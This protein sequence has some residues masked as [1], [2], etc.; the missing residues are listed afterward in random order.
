MIDSKELR[1]LAIYILGIL[2]FTYT[3][4]FIGHVKPIPSKEFNEHLVFYDDMNSYLSY[5]KQ[6]ANG[7]WLFQN[8]F[9]PEEHSGVFINL[10][11]LVLGKISRIFKT[12]LRTDFQIERIVGA[13]TLIFGF[14]LLSS[15]FIQNKFVRKVALLVFSLGGGFGW[16]YILS[17]A[18]QKLFH[19]DILTIPFVPR[20]TSSGL[21]PFFQ[22]MLN[23]HF[24]IAHGILLLTYSLYTI[25]EM[26]NDVKYYVFSGISCA[27]LGFVRPFDMLVC[28]LA[29]FMFVILLYISKRELS[30]HQ[31]F[32]RFLPILMGLPVMLYNLYVFKLHPVFK[33]WN[34]QNVFTERPL[35]ILLFSMGFVPFLVLNNIGGFANLREKETKN[36]FLI[37]TIA[38]ISVLAF[39]T[40]F[41]KFAPQFGT[42]WMGSLVI[43]GIMKVEKPLLS[44]LSRKRYIYFLLFAFLLVNSFTSIW[45]LKWKCDEVWQGKHHTDSRLITAF[46]WLE[47]NSSPSDIVLSSY[48]TG[49][50]IPRYSGNKVFCGYG[51]NTVDFNGK[52]N[53]VKQF[54][55]LETSDKY[56]LDLIKKYKIEYLFHGPSER[57]IGKYIPEI[58]PF[59]KQVYQNDIV[60]I[61]SVK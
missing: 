9:T 14:Y 60:M 61:Y 53:A 18:V 7:R 47:E 32:L 3:P 11:W 45:L 42:I 4:Y 37:G 26:K 59:L 57:A 33:W 2:L 30:L 22:M 51:Y 40:P 56:R 41:L 44:A 19:S 38:A 31:T 17:L 55:N 34:I 36:I 15:L 20:D 35:M 39:S 6:S 50:K 48:P 5:V 27:V 21:H 12:S 52:I 16:I 46:D 54:F 1:F 24:S 49:N 28:F 23:P 13:I 8:Q 58:S 10:K 29:V 43:F 25:G